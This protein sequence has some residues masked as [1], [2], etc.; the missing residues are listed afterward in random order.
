MEG[1]Q[2]QSALEKGL[3]CSSACCKQKLNNDN[4]KGHDEINLAALVEEVD[5]PIGW[6]AAILDF[7]N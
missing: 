2:I 6:T 3:T 7:K 1:Q 5:T 4:L